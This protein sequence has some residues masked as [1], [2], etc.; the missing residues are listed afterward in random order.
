MVIDLTGS[1]SRIVH[2]PLPE[3]DPKQRRPDI[4]QAQKLL[5]WKPKTALSEGLPKTIAYFERLLA[6]NSSGI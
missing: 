5:S 2:R 1:K 4:S 3:D 6:D